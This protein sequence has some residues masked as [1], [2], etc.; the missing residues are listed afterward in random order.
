MLEYFVSLE[1]TYGILLDKEQRNRYYLQSKLLKDKMKQEN[2]S[3]L[4]EAFEH[5]IL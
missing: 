1:K 3:V 4:K 2:P 5:P